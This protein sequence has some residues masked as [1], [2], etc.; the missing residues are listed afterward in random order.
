MLRRL[1][2]VAYQY[3][4]QKG[5]GR[6]GAEVRF[7]FVADEVERAGA[8]HVV[9]RMNGRTGSGTHSLKGVV[10]QDLIALL[11]AALQEQQRRIAA[12]SRDRAREAL[13]FASDLE[14]ERS[15]R[16]HDVE[17]LSTQLQAL[18]SRLSALE[19]CCNR[20]V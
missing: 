5:H 10:Y 6:R 1:R 19:S 15:A 12:E 16:R 17:A 13:A 8:P 2:P 4:R 3:R 20:S 18:S 11:V 14:S 7:G 9:R